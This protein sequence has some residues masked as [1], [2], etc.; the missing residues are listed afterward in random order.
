MVAKI[1]EISSVK[2]NLSFD[3]PWS[4][5]KKE[6]DS[7]YRDV[8]KTAKIK[9]FRPG[10]IPRKVLETYYG[11]QAE[12]RAISNLVNKFYWEALKENNIVPIADPVIDQKGIEKD[13]SFAFSAIVEVEPVIEPKDFIGLELEKGESVITDA[14]VQVKLEELR[15]MHSTLESIEGDRGIIEG[16]FAY[17][18]FEGKLDG[19]SMKEMSQENYLLEVGSKRFVPGFE[20][21]IIGVKKGESKE[22][23]VKFPDDYPSKE[24]VGKDVSFSVTVRDVKKKVLPELDENFVKNFEKYESLGELKEDIKKTLEEENKD[25]ANAELKRLIIDKL[26]E[27]NEFEIPSSL[28]E[29]QIFSMMIDAQRRMTLGGMDPEKAAE[30]SS[31][32]R[33]KFKDKAE[34][35]VKTTFLINSIAEK[36]SI[37]VDE[38]DV[39][40]RLKDFAGKY[41]QDYESLKKSYEEG[42]RIEHLKMGILEKKTLDFIEGKAKI[43]YIENL[44]EK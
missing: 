37:T 19:K 29:R 3:V 10:K 22:I 18:D 1:E 2:K 32:L 35:I 13:K 8:G 30:V 27:K 24:I 36:E 6:L 14:D 31:N 12:D 41:A 43:T 11:D 21:Q 28:V 40:E 33:D 34:Q 16:D 4:D 23:V 26:L 5:V 7:V 20:D 39:E 17:I 38:K 15:H 9:G 44:E 25:R 42:D